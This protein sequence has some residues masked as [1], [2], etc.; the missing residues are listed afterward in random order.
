[1]K[2]IAIA[3]IALLFLS[4]CFQTKQEKHEQFIQAIQKGDLSAVRDYIKTEKEINFQTKN[5]TPLDIAMKTK[6]KKIVVELL[7]AGAK[8]AYMPLPPLS[9]TIASVLPQSEETNEELVKQMINKQTVKERDKDGNTPLHYAIDSGDIELVRLLVQHGA[10]VNATN[11]A[12]TTPLMKAAQFG[13]TEIVKFLYAH[14]ADINR[15]DDQGETALSK[16]VEGNQVATVQFL[17]QAGANVNI[18]TTIGKTALMTAAEYGYD[19]LV[20]LLLRHGADVNVKDK[21]GN[22]ALSLAQ[23]WKHE[24]I[25]RQLKQKGAR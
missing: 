2:K 11:E 23:Y 7:R 1:M 10:D 13:Q 25:I 22:T 17:L 16:A 19:N 15:T 6:H 5:G 24:S 20:S 9:F 14:G 18:K 8:S 3:M 12:G 21:T 4:G